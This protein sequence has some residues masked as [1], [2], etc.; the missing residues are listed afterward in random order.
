MMLE[1]NNDRIADAMNNWLEEIFR[2][3]PK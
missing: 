2:L 3:P 1:K